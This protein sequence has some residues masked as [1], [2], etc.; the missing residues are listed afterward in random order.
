MQ[1]TN[2]GVLVLTLIEAK[3]TRDYKLLE[4]ICPY[5]T[6]VFEGH[7]YKSKSLLYAG[8]TPKWQQ[9]FAFEVTSQ[10]DFLMLR[11]WDKDVIP[12]A[13]VCFANINISDLT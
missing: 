10:S 7:K 8:Q 11:V 13:L 3:L 1:N 5:V 6:L 4:K 9:P 2:E 12:N